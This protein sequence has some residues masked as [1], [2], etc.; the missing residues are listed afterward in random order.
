MKNQLIRLEFNEKDNVFHYV[1]EKE[2]VKPIEN[3]FNYKTIVECCSIEEAETLQ[4]YIEM[5]G[6]KTITTNDVLKDLSEVKIFINALLA[7]NLIIESI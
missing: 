1:Y 2:A 4:S 5:K 7:R 6:R 3:T